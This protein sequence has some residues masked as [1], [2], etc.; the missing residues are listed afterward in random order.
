MGQK[1]RKTKNHC[2]LRSETEKTLSGL[3]EGKKEP[4]DT[5]QSRA[6][7]SDPNNNNNNDNNDNISFH[8]HPL[9]LL[10]RRNEDDES[11]HSNNN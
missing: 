4:C 1:Q 10:K 6:H 9:S 3:T 5:N 7:P 2:K 8:F 11:K